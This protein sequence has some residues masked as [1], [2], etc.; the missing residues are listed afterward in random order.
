MAEKIRAVFL[1]RDGVLVKAPP[2]RPINKVE[3]LELLPLVAQ[4]M[5][6]FKSLSLKTIV[7]SNQGGIAR[8]FMTDEVM[9]QMNEE[10]DRQL[11]ILGAPKIDLYRWCPHYPTTEKKRC[12][13]RKPKPGM[14][15]DAAKLLNIDLEK[16]FLVG[17]MATDLEAGKNA[18]I[19]WCFAVKSPIS[20]FS[21][22]VH[23]HNS[24]FHVS[25][26]IQNLYP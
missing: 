16:S 12:S 24:L 3:E 6:V 21:D 8:G 4:A 7:V 22:T 2:G 13:C 25:K 18:G 17:D 9:V 15:L 20:D 14:I 26:V 5:K 10:L 19:K 1:D 23:Q 11:T